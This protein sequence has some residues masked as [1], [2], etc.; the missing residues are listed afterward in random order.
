MIG[1]LI[2]THLKIETIKISMFYHLGDID[3]N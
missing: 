2:I 1:E 3:R